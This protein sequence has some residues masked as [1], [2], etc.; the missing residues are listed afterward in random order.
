VGVGDALTLAQLSGYFARKGKAIQ[1]RVGTDTSFSD[2]R[3][4]PAVLIG[5]FSNQWIMEITRDFRYSFE[6]EDNR[7]IIRDQLAPGHRWERQLTDPPSDF[8]IITRVFASKTGK[9][10]VIAAGL[11]H[12]GTQVAG[13]F[14]TN[15]AYLQDALRGAP[16]DW[17]S[18]N[19]QFVLRAEMV[20]RTPAPP[21]TLATHFW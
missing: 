6:V 9:P 2:L 4:A 15:P 16:K 5:A 13:Q 7:G 21:R 12:F 19:L 20:G 3:D 1:L 18:K 11:S 14:L 8:A 17:Q 10:V